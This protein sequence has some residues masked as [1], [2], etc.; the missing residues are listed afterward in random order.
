LLANNF[1]NAQ[2]DRKHEFSYLKPEN[3]CLILGSAF[4]KRQLSHRHPTQL[5]AQLGDSILSPWRKITSDRID[6]RSDISMERDLFGEPAT[7]PGSRPRTGIFQIV[8]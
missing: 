8:I 6:F 5:P 7:S 2:R 1:S 3:S 4:P